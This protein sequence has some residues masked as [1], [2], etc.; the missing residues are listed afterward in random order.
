M[1]I[2]KPHIKDIQKSLEWDDNHL[3]IVNVARFRKKEAA[4]SLILSAQFTNLIVILHWLNLM[5]SHIKSN[6]NLQLIVCLV[7]CSNN[8]MYLSGG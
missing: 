4:I 5:I 8:H 7:S 6:I 3:N 2:Y 1:I